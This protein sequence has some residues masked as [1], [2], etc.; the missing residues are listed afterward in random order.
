[1]MKSKLIKARKVHRC[2]VCKGYISPGQPYELLKDRGPKYSFGTDAA[3]GLACKQVGIVYLQQ[4][5]CINC[6]DEEV[7]NMAMTGFEKQIANLRT[8]KNAI[9]RLA[10]KN[11]DGELSGVFKKAHDACDGYIQKYGSWRT[12]QKKEDGDTN[13]TG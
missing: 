1:M 7:W 12:W 10:P 8:L 3:M 4:R 9:A 6:M 13:I 2:N 5:L 11:A